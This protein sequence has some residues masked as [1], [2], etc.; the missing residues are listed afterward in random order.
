MIRITKQDIYDESKVLQYFTEENFF[1]I[2]TEKLLETVKRAENLYYAA[3]RHLDNYFVNYFGYRVPGDMKYAFSKYIEES[4]VPEDLLTWGKTELSV[5]AESLEKITSKGYELNIIDLYLHMVSLKKAASD[6]RKFYND[7][8]GCEIVEGNNGEK[9]SKVSFGIR[10]VE[11][12]RFQTHSPD[13]IGK[14]RFI[15]NSMRAPKGY[16]ILSADFPQIDGKGVLYTYLRTPE[17]MSIMKETTDSY[18]VFRELT[19]RTKYRKA[20]AKVEGIKKSSKFVDVSEE[21][22][23]IANYV[24]EITPFDNKNERDNYKLHA[25]STSY[26]KASS[27]DFL[28]QQIINDIEEMLYSN[29]VYAYYTTLIERYYDYGIPIVT[30]SPKGY[31]RVISDSKTHKK[32]VKD[33]ALNAPI[34][35]MSSEII[36]IFICRVIDYFREKGY[37]EK[38]MCLA[39][40]R[41]DEPIFI[42]KEEVLMD[43]LK[44]LS[45]ARNILVDG[46]LPFQMKWLIGPAYKEYVDAYDVLLDK[47]VELED[48]RALAEEHL[49]EVPELPIKVYDT[50]YV[51]SRTLPN[52]SIVLMLVK[53]EWLDKYT[54]YTLELDIGGEVFDQEAF[55]STIRSVLLNEPKSKHGRIIISPNASSDK[56]FLDMEDDSYL[57]ISDLNTT[58]YFSVKGCLASYIAKYHKD[59]VTEDDRDFIEI[60]KQHKSKFTKGTLNV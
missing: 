42:I 18:L 37:T 56:K 31:T 58:A 5:S 47:F 7:I 17:M 45:L 10:Q 4:N 25:L 51:A 15:K 3:Y 53:E 2:E 23:I 30:H 57:F 38:D 26:G 13:P 49:D 41:H 8:Q 50:Y 22:N 6:S 27:N 60:F 11:N 48:I 59:L 29:E 21:E 24:D 39:F 34:Q 52:G 54:V 28:G 9:L 40:N 33:T 44:F 16:L 20:R 43:N 35:T 12:R 32:S 55:I 46:W 14:S 1:Y 19:K 36:Y